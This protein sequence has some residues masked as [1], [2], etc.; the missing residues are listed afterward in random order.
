MG[1]G[2]EA[3]SDPR[4]AGSV[5]LRRIPYM[6]GLIRAELCSA[7]GSTMAVLAVA[8]LSY[9]DSKSVAHTVIVSAAFSL[10]T[11]VLGTYAG[12]VAARMSHRRLLL[13]C[14]AVKLVL[15]L[16]MA[17]L[18]FVDALSVPLLLATSMLLGAVAAFD[19]PAWMELEQDIVPPDRLDEANATLSAYASGATLVGGI[20]G[21]VLL[22]A[23][24][25]WALLLLNALTYLVFIGVLVQARTPER[26]TSQAER[27]GIGAIVRYVRSNEAIRV[28]FAQTALLGLFVAP[29]AQLLPAIA[30]ALSDGTN[31]GI[32]TGAVAV[33]AIGLASVVGL[34][35]RRFSRMA[36][37]NGTFVVAGLLLA[38][39]G[40]FGDRLVGAPLWVVVLVA[41]V[42]FGL[43]LSLAQ[44]VLTAIV[45]T[46]VDPAMEGSVFS[47]YAIIYTFC[48]PLGGIALGLFADSR[49]VWDA[50]LA[51]GLLVTAT[52]LGLVALR[53]RRGRVAGP[54]AVEPGRER[55]GHVD[56]LLRGH[57]LH[58]HRH[59]ERPAR[60]R[61]ATGPAP[62]GP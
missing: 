46:R 42:P 24:G 22:G 37:L 61:P 19:Y 44:A 36:I 59:R 45:Q 56:G 9:N 40:V 60:P 31:L 5:P 21:G 7:V 55:S 32:L 58:L 43:L 20:A 57:V 16:V 14:N 2:E 1:A 11:A 38:T 54:V 8:F 33:G 49:D 23:T 12:R 35:R 26:D 53:R 51:A 6:G 17:A 41:L 29:V 48:A 52:S 34:L 10:P 25:P 39:L 50:L 18:A 62:G 15:Y 28:A 13:I 47:V 4:R 3:T 30:G 27:V